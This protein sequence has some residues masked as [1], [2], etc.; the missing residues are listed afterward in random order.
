MLQLE[1]AL[2]DLRIDEQYRE[3]GKT[4]HNL[5]VDEIERIK[6]IFIES[7]FKPPTELGEMVIGQIIYDRF[8]KLLSEVIQDETVNPI[9]LLEIAR[10][11]CGLD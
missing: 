3:V 11:A 2:Q 6:Q 1:Q 10:E 9:Q 8:T 7:G 5:T 4:W